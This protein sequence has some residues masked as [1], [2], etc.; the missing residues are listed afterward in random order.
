[1][2]RGELPPQAIDAAYEKLA[3]IAKAGNSKALAIFEGAASNFA[4]SSEPQQRKALPSALYA[5]ALALDKLGRQDEAV[6]VLAELIERFQDD[7]NPE[8]QNVVSEAREAREEMLD[9]ESG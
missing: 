9:G 4:N 8:I 5:K 2:P 3:R 6:L 7:E 1:M